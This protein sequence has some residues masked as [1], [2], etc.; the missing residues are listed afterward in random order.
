MEVG[1]GYY[2]KIKATCVLYEFSYMTHTMA[3]LD[4]RDGRDDCQV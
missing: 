4:L 3:K 2:G 1:K